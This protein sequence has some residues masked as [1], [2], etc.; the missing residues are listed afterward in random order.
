MKDS[1]AGIRLGEP[2]R[3]ILYGVGALTALLAWG[4]GYRLGAAAMAVLVLGGLSGE[5]AIHLGR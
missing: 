4:W 5:V 3:G 1:R 2:L